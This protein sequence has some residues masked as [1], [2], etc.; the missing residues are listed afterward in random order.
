MD[1][2]SGTHD[3]VGLVA[4]AAHDLRL[5]RVRVGGPGPGS[6]LIEPAFG[7][8]CG[9]DLHYAAHGA[10]GTAVL[11]EPLVLG[12]ELGGVIAAVG[13]DVDRTIGERV[14]VYPALTC[15]HCAAC[16]RG[17]TQLCDAVRYLG[18]AAHL[19]HRQGGFATALVVPASAAVAIPDALGLETAA[20]IEPFAVSL[21][22]V[23]RSGADASSHVV[24]NGVGPIG[25]F[26]VIALR[27][28]GVRRITAI[29]VSPHALGLAAALGADAAL[30]PRS[31]A[32]PV[33]ADVA[34][35]ATGVPAAWAQAVHT[36]RAGGRM[37]QVGLLPAGPI[38]VPLADLMSHEIE[39]RNSYRFPRTTFDQAIDLVAHG[40]DL[41]PVV[42]D[43]FPLAEAAAAFAVAADSARSSKVLLRLRD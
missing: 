32:L 15:G 35:E 42:T 10:A 8:I 4:H 33:D 37:V 18:S 23:N 11:R 7:G 28:I 17:D 19:P 5:E 29:D 26:A 41:L 31:D 30:D 25:L 40:V 2:P 34:I 43:V 38:T 12:H 22:A 24:V 9:S 20:L 27:S 14:A 39:Y 21:H 36:V 16:L 3:A 6:V 1:E 13:P